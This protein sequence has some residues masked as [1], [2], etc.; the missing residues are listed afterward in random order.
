MLSWVRAKK[1]AFMDEL[2]ADDLRELMNTKMS[3]WKRVSLSV[4]AGAGISCY[5]NPKAYKYKWPEYK[6]VVDVYRENGTNNMAYS[7]MSFGQQKNKELPKNFD[8]YIYEEMNNW[9][10]YKPTMAPPH[11]RDL[12]HPNE[13]NYKPM[14]VSIEDLTNRDKSMG[15]AIV[16]LILVS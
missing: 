1:A 3:K 12:L 15:D 2:Q 9:L 11:F 16:Q 7:N 10:R 14:N 5:R 13:C 8:I 6:K 4:N